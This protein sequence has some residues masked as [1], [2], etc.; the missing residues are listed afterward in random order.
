MIV[1]GSDLL[2]NVFS[3]YNYTQLIGRDSHLSRRR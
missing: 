3:L 2:L 1:P